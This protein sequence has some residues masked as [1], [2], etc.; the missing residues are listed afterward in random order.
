M[1]PEQETALLAHGQAEADRQMLETLLSLDPVAREQFDY[2]HAHAYTD[3]PLVDF[4]QEWRDVY[5][6]PWI[7]ADGRL[8][9]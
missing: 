8:I 5:E 3:M 2:I 4:V 7:G 6:S 9:T 1:T